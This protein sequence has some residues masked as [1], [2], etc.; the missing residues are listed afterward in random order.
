VI[1]EMCMASFLIFIALANL[2]VGYF[3]GAML[4]RPLPTSEMLLVSGGIHSIEAS[5][6]FASQC[7][8]QEN[9][10]VDEHSEQATSA[11]SS[12]TNDAA[13]KAQK[14]WTTTCTDIRHDIATLRDR[15]QYALSASD[16]KINQSL[17]AEVQGR[18][19]SWQKLLQEKL[20]AASEELVRDP[21]ATVDSVAPELCLAQIE[22]L[23]TNLKLLDWSESSES[24]LRKLEREIE[25][26]KNVLPAGM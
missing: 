20:V 1:E 8:S 4:L 7:D 12:S 25:A 15:I 17:A 6:P 11:D 13:A 26:V 24:I 5:A 21:A 10:S 9:L 19:P 23:Q 18:T 14:C 16:K 22:T 2:G 3:L